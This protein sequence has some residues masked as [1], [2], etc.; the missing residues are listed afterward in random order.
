MH[1]L[2]QQ[3][4]ELKQTDGKLKQTDGRTYGHYQI[5]YAPATW[6]IL[7]GNRKGFKAQTVH[8]GEHT[9][10]QTDATKRIISLASRSIINFDVC[11][12]HQEVYVLT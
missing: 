9:D 12:K 5:Y 2:G 4:A 3:I 1:I 7:K 10:R 8:P 11:L 6:L